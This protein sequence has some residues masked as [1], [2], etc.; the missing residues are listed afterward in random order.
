MESLP[1]KVPVY[2][3]GLFWG[4]ASLVVAVLLTAVGLILPP[5][6]IAK[7]LLVI[8]WLL[9]AI[10][11]WLVFDTLSYKAMTWF[12]TLVCFAL[13]AFSINWL[14][15]MRMLPTAEDRPPL[16]LQFVPVPPA[17]GYNK[18]PTLRGLLPRGSANSN[19]LIGTPSTQP[20][21]EK[22]PKPKL[23]DKPIPPAL[24]PIIIASS[25]T[26]AIKADTNT[27]EITVTFGNTTTTEANG[28]IEM[29]S[30]L[31]VN[32]IESGRGA[33]IERDVAFAPPP[34]TYQLAT[35]TIVSPD[36]ITL[37]Q[38]IGATL[39]VVASVSYPDRGGRTIYHFKGNTVPKLDHLDMAETS[40]ERV[41]MR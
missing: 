18:K 37:F 24:Y 4:I 31:Y 30:I 35:D 41:P 19:A 23:P 21:A 36:T 39:T 25:S 6:T 17:A 13:M 32:G 8:G 40:W 5:T 10:P 7:W 9:S 33:P 20:A 15:G 27:I 14:W 22:N 1:P 2:E 29:Q 16:L 3:R 34:N 38:T 12:L 28:H 26:V 11:L